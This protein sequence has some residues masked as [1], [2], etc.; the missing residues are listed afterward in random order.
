MC[1]VTGCRSPSARAVTISQTYRPLTVPAFDCSS[2]RHSVRNATFVT[3][4]IGASTTGLASS[5]GPMRT[6]RLPPAHGQLARR[7]VELERGGP[8][9]RAGFP[10]ELTPLGHLELVAG[11]LELLHQHAQ[12]VAKRGGITGEVL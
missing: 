2:S 1:M 4:A 7:L 3:P 5:I 8:L 10:V 11:R 6:G 12:V 9:G